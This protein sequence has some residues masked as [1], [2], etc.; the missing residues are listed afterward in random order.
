VGR[1]AQGRKGGE[2]VT[3]EE[4]IRL[5]D[6]NARESGDTWENDVCAIRLRESESGESPYPA[7]CR[8]PL[9]IAGR[10]D[11]SSESGMTLGLSRDERFAIMT[12]ADIPL[13]SEGRGSYLTSVLVD[14][15]QVA[16]REL[17]LSLFDFGVK[18]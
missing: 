17:M 5:A 8:C 4:V 16:L 11:N 10:R 9:N 12:A 6:K 15:K 14:P 13:R 3:L 1:P 18:P 7:G 2:V